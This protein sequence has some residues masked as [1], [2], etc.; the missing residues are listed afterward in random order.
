MMWMPTTRMNEAPTS[1]ILKS[2]RGI[3]SDQ[4]AYIGYDVTQMLLQVLAMDGDLT[5]HLLN[6]SLYD[7]VVCESSLQIIDA[8]WDA[9]IW[10]YPMGS[11]L[12][13]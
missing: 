1:I 13:R 2:L 5:D 11:Q 8:I 7:G 9:L 10:T 12:I 6:A 4:F 3:S